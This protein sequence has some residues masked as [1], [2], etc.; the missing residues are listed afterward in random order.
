[1]T[2]QCTNS[3]STQRGASLHFDWTKDLTVST[4]YILNYGTFNIGSES[5][6]YARNAVI[7]LKAGS[8]TYPKSKFA[9]KSDL[10]FNSTNAQ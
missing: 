8:A 2:E 4:T 10:R 1:M 6:P 3:I 7:N 9:N 5:C